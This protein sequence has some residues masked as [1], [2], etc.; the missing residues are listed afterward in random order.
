[1]TVVMEYLDPKV[2]FVNAMAVNHTKDDNL[3]IAVSNF[4][5]IRQS[6]RQDA[7]SAH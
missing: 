7:W 2:H 4:S 3:A 6:L 1:M 5:G